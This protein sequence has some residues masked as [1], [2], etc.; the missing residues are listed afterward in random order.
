[1]FQNT[2]FVLPSYCMRRLW[3]SQ[4]D[5][6]D[7]KGPNFLVWRVWNFGDEIGN[8]LYSEFFLP[9]RR[10]LWYGMNGISRLLATAK[11]KHSFC[12]QVWMP[13]GNWSSPSGDFCT[14]VAKKIQVFANC[15]FDSRMRLKPEMNAL[16]ITLLIFCVAFALLEPCT[17]HFALMFLV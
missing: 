6:K 12:Y 16:A 3:R 7:F 15:Q 13:W 1:M 10:F 17:E 8:I 14:L 11:R 9:N 4:I 5:M 2:G